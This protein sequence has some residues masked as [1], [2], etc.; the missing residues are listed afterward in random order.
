VPFTKPLRTRIAAHRL[1][2]CGGEKALV[3]GRGEER[4]F[5]PEAL[6]RRAQGAWTS[7]GLAPIGL[8]EC[9][10]IYAAFM[11]AAGVNSKGLSIYMGTR[12]SVV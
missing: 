8:H 6:V 12:V 11:I 9:R 4:A 3:F 2:S 7:A 1:L 5:S 10:H